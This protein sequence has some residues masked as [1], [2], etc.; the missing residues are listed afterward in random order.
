MKKLLALPCCMILAAGA[1]TGCKYPA[2]ECIWRYDDRYGHPVRHMGVYICA[3]GY[4]LYAK[5]HLNDLLSGIQSTIIR[6]V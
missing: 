3:D 5:A 2:W 4:S 1:L 6:E